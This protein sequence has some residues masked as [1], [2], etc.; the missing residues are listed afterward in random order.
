MRADKYLVEHGFFDT[1]ARAAAAIKA[2]AVVI[3]GASL[4]KPSQNIPDGASVQAKA[5]HPWVSRGGVKLAH[6]LD[7]SGIDVTGSVAL[8]VGASTGGFTDVLLTNG[9]AKVYAVDVGRE[10]L[11]RKLKSDDR[12]ISMES[13]DARYIEADLFAPLP[14]IVVCDASFISAMKVL[15]RPLSIM[16]TGASLI[17]LVKPQFEVGRDNI[18]KGGLVKSGEVAEA[19]LE[20]VQHWVQE[21][22]WEV[23]GT[24]LS[25]ITGGSGNTE[26]LLWAQKL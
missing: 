24:A 22:G 9:A 5:A 11:H 13:T 25:P 18:G 8:D 16:K 4:K 3:N 12:V 6:A 23:K 14:T 17:T 20:T 19:S 15:E 2:G 26:Y 21:Q 10:Q 1:R 7:V